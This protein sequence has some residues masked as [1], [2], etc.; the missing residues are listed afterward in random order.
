MTKKTHM[1]HNLFL[2]F[3]KACVKCAS[4]EAC[5]I[6]WPTLGNTFFD[7]CQQHTFKLYMYS[8]VRN[9]KSKL[10]LAQLELDRKFNSKTDFN[11][12]LFDLSASSAVPRHF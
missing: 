2:M 3:N 1:K 9:Q 7:F 4:P 5:Y 8:S 6:F 11:F 10:R 12:Q